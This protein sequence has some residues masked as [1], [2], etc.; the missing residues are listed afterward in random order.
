MKVINHIFLSSGDPR[1]AVVMT[2]VAGLIQFLFG[3]LNLGVLI[4]FISFPV[5]SA[6]TSAAAVTIATTQLK[7]LLGLKNIS[8][9]FLHAIEGVIE[10][11]TR[12][13]DGTE[14]TKK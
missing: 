1:L 10:K 14:G 2:L 9:E 4:D 13:F 5:I 12:K 3:L 11:I 7:S 6:F 8:N